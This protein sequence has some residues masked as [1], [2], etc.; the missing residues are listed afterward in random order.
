MIPNLFF[1]QLQQEVSRF[2]KNL[3]LLFQ[4]IR[5]LIKSPDVFFSFSVVNQTPALRLL[6]YLHH[7]NLLGEHHLSLLMPEHDKKMRVLCQTIDTLEAQGR[8]F[9]LDKT[10]LG[11]L[12]GSEGVFIEALHEFFVKAEHYQIMENLDRNSIHLFLNMALEYQ[13]VEA[14]WLFQAQ[15]NQGQALCSR[16]IARHQKFITRAQKSFEKTHRF[17]I[18]PQSFAPLTVSLYQAK[19]MHWPVVAIEHIT[20]SR[21]ER[22]AQNYV[23]ARL[24]EKGESVKAVAEVLRLLINIGKLHTLEPQSL[25]AIMEKPDKI[26]HILR[27]LKKIH[28]LSCLNLIQESLLTALFCCSELRLSIAAT[29]LNDVNQNS[30][31]QIRYENLWNLIVGDQ[32]L[33]AMIFIPQQPQGLL[34]TQKGSTASKAK[35]ITEHHQALCPEW[36]AQNS[37]KS[38]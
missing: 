37:I 4:A 18:N 22:L 25:L 32:P 34:F 15:F 9:L 7:N 8:S 36:L 27:I 12:L 20:A 38:R 28:D 14:V 16:H 13:P 29:L 31:A 30:K 1:N 17:D 19:N 3:I 2:S 10:V 23:I 21:C 26:P 33:L 11:R 24:L 35:A 6:R 5:L